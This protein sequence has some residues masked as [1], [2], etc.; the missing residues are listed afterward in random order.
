MC[1]CVRGVIIACHV[2]MVTNSWPPLAFNSHAEPNLHS[3]VYT[4]WK[5]SGFIM[6]IQLY[7]DIDD[8]I[9]DVHMRMDQ[10]DIT[11]C[12]CTRMYE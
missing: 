4:D 11:T 7:I 12:M 10:V 5:D 6:H 2:D 1:V 9:S 3:H 8:C